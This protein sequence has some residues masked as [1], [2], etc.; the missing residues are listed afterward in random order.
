MFN[1]FE[2]PKIVYLLNNSLPLYITG[3]T[4][5]LVVES[6]Y[7]DTQITPIYEGFP[8]MNNSVTTKCGGYLINK[9]IKHYLKSE[10]PQLSADALSF[11]AI[12]DI[13]FKYCKLLKLNQEQHYE[14]LK[15]D[16][17]KS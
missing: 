1:K 7:F 8:L 2:V 5:G 3:L 14:T 12:E 6:G 11:T 15:E 9:F 10:N 17:M 13:K 4:T 16:C